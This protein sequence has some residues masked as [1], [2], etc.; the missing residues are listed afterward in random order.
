MWLIVAGIVLISGV[1]F[2]DGV[3]LSDQDATAIRQV[4]DVARASPAINLEASAS[5]AQ[6]CL[7]LIGRIAASKKTDEKAEPQK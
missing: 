6:Y 3:S 4:C 1:A 7:S 2:A 5:V